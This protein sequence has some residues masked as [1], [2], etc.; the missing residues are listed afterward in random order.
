MQDQYEDIAGILAK[1]PEISSAEDDILKEW[2]GLSVVNQKI[3]EDLISPEELLNMMKS[4][5]Q[6]KTEKGRI[7]QRVMNDIH[8]R[9]DSAEKN[10]K[11]IWFRKWQTYVAAASVIIIASV[12]IYMWQLRKPGT[13]TLPAPTVAKLN[14]ASP[15]KYKAKL[16]LADG[17]VII[18]DSAK[19][20][21]LVQQGGLIVFN[22]DGKLVYEKVG[23]TDKVLYN[24]LTT[25]KG[26]TYATELSDGTKV[27]LN[28]QS[29]LRYPIAFTGDV[30]KVEITGEAYFEVA[31]S[32]AVSA[33]GEKTKRRFVVSV[34][35]M[36]V[37]VLGTHFN[38]N[39][40]A[41]EPAMKTTLLEGKVKVRSAATNEQTILAPGEQAQI[42]T[43]TQALNKT[44]DV[45]IDAE[46]AW[47]FGMFQFNNVDLKTVMRQ[48]ERWYDVQVVYQGNVGDFEFLGKIPR[49]MNLSQV[50]TVL[51]KVNVHFNIDGKKIIVTP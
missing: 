12:F 23:E 44:K 4:V 35:G 27:W 33:T 32:I 11:V 37:E 38:I 3:F 20:G 49:N 15:G 21:R 13:T 14:D 19:S 28:S 30:R 42:N 25:T 29:T 26:E 50:L 31:P 16:T 48:L 2:I 6:C 10:I 41:D 34:N 45:D 43:Q 51:Q 22:K 1:Y 36:E 40:Y 17:T 9:P 39:S 18:L 24:T 7:W 8:A 46:V 5:E 47:R